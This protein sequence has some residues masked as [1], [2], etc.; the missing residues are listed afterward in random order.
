MAA[1]AS[2]DMRVMR[3]VSCPP[4]RMASTMRAICSG[5]LPAP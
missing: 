1:A 2:T 4:E 3:M 5:V